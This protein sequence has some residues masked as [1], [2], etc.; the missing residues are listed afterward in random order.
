MGLYR[1]C[2][3]Q[4]VYHYVDVYADSEEKAYDIGY[5]RIL[6]GHAD[7]TDDGDFYDDG[8]L[9]VLDENA[10]DPELSKPTEEPDVVY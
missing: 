8:D 9:E 7:S 10:T 3:G 6:D 2:L 4:S 1:V 5:E